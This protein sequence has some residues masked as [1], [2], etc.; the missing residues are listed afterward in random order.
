MK[1]KDGLGGESPLYLG[2]YRADIDSLYPVKT[3]AAGAD[4]VKWYYP[5]GRYVFEDTDGLKNGM[6]YFYDVTAYSAIPDTLDEGDPDVLGDETVE[7]VELESRPTAI[8]DQAVIPVWDATP[9]M[10]DIF[11]VPNPYVRGGQ[12]MGWDLN[13]SDRDPTGT[14]IAFVNLPLEKCEVKI[15][16]LAGDLVQTLDHDPEFEAALGRES[17]SGTVFWNLISRN[18]QDIVSGVYLFSVKCGG[19]TKVGRFVIIR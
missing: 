10:D 4:S 1:P 7:F 5:V 3:G 19:D 8:E 9:S 6:L 17:N 18:G 12:P 15:Y 11:V 14:K 16:T 2:K 13:P